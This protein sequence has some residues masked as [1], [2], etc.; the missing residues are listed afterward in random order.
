MSHARNKKQWRSDSSASWETGHTVINA[1]TKACLEGWGRHRKQKS[2]ALPEVQVQGKHG[3]WRVSRSFK[4]QGMKRAWVKESKCGSACHVVGLEDSM[5]PSMGFREML[6]SVYRTEKKSL[7][8]RRPIRKPLKCLN[9]R[10]WKSQ[11]AQS[12]F[13]YCSAFCVCGFCI[14]S[15]STLVGGIWRKILLYGTHTFLEIMIS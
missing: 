4:T 6:L 5:Q 11:L 15:Y 10:R 9:E 12:D 1:K 2:F 8:A 3:P 13:D 14:C 7:Q